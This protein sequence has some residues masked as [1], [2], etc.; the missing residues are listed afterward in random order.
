MA[1]QTNKVCGGICLSIST[2]IA[3][4][5]YDNNALC[6]RF[7]FGLKPTVQSAIMQ[8]GHTTMFDDLKDQAIR[9]DQH[10]R[11]LHLTTEA[12]ESK[13]SDAP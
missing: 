5:N 11:H 13:A 9:F 2:L 8:Q 4:L 3:P 12:D 1:P 7:C 10:Q 6:G